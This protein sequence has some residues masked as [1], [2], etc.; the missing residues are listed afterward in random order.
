MDGIC[1]YLLW[2]REHFRGKV[3]TRLLIRVMSNSLER[4]YILNEAETFYSLFHVMINQTEFKTFLGPNNYP[5][6]FHFFEWIR[7]VILHVYAK[8]LHNC[9]PGRYTKKVCI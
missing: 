2:H 1:S 3:L 5:V 9:L 4:F 7:N 8:S 6:Y